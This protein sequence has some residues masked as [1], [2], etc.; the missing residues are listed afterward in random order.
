MGQ[1]GPLEKVMAANSKNLAWRV[2]Q[3]EETGELQSMAL[4][5]VGHDLVTQQ[6]AS[7]KDWHA[8]DWI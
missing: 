4:Q 7:M 8:G 6:Q 2:L 1:E 5:R 3:T